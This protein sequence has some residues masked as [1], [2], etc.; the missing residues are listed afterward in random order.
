MRKSQTVWS[1]ERRAVVVEEDKTMP[2][3]AAVLGG[4]QLRIMNRFMLIAMGSHWKVLGYEM[5][6]IYTFR[7]LPHMDKAEEGQ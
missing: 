4:S 6:L 7:M 3:E 2:A 1:S 5:S